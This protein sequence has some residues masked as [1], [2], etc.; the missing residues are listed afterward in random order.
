MAGEVSLHYLVHTIDAARSKLDL[1]YAIVLVIE[2]I[3]NLGRQF[4][5]LSFHR[6]LKVGIS[7][8]NFIAPVIFA[9]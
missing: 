9:A 1:R 7:L 4:V 8:S 3:N 5:E 6:V 2:P